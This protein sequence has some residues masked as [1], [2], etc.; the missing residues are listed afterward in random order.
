[1]T[2]QSETVFA[3]KSRLSDGKSYHLLDYSMFYMNIRTNAIDRT[4]AWL[5]VH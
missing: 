2:D 5:A 3:K 4:T 1:M